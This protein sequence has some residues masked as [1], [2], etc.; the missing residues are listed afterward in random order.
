MIAQKDPDLVISI[1]PLEERKR[2]VIKVHPLPTPEDMAQIKETVNKIAAQVDRKPRL[3]PR[4]TSSDA[5]SIEARSRDVIVKG[6]VIYEELKKVFEGQLERHYQEAFLLHV[7]LMV[8]RITF[9]Q[10]YE[11][12]GNVAADTLLAEAELVEKIEALFAESEL[13]IN[14]AEISALLIYIQEGA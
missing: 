5:Q 10:Q 14:R 2:P 8:H 6:Y 7:F 13:A 12:E 1:F 9:A 3:V 11:N 4:K